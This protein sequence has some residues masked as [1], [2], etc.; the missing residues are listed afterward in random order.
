MSFKEINSAVQ[1]KGSVLCSGKRCDQI[2]LERRANISLEFTSKIVLGYY[3]DK[4]LEE[5]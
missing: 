3:G 4:L 5:H 1:F 2:Y